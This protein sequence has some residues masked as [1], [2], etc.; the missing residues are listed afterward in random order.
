MDR[1]GKVDDPESGAPGLGR[2]Q[3]TS[4][5]GGA[6]RGEG[7]GKEKEKW[8]RWKL[9]VNAGDDIPSYLIRWRNA[10]GKKDTH[11]TMAVIEIREN[12]DKEEVEEALL[13]ATQDVT[14][15]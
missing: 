12:A 11:A 2:R 5:S 4:G 8:H 14:G 9:Q 3:V 6:R 1:D 7:E 13:E 10:Q 15:Y